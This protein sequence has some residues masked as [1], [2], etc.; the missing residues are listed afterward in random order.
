ML[1]EDLGDPKLVQP[2]PCIVRI[3]L[4]NS[5]SVSEGVARPEICISIKSGSPHSRITI[6]ITV[7]L[8]AFG[9]ILH[10]LLLLLLRFGLI[11]RLRI[12]LLLRLLVLRLR[13]RL[14]ILRRWPRLRCSGRARALTNGDVRCATD[15]KSVV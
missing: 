9:L 3:Q 13:P 8:V 15:R 7:T 5:H 14:L 10:L 6:I 12:L 2:V 4:P 1:L 11:P